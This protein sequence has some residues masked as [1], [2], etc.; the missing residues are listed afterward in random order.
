MFYINNK[1][2][3]P[4]KIAKIA[5]AKPAPYNIKC[6]PSYLTISCEITDCIAMVIP[7][8]VHMKEGSQVRPNTPIISSE[9]ED[10]L[11]NVSIVCCLL[12]S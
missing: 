12:L 5:P 1:I 9:T 2:P 7:A 11:I 3:L 10:T 4:R 8:L 6:K